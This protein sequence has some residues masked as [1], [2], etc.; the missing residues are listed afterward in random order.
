MS[1]HSKNLQNLDLFPKG[2]GSGGYRRGS[3]RK[4]AEPTVTMRVPQSLEAEIKALIKAHKDRLKNA[5]KN[6]EH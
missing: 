1:I 3:G 4:K 5:S 2:K 6:K